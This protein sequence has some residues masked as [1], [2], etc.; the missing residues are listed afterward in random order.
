MDDTRLADGIPTLKTDWWNYGGLTRDVS[1]V[2]VPEHYID[3]FD[4]HLKRGTKNEIEGWVHVQGAPVGQRSKS[5]WK[6]AVNP[7][8]PRGKTDADGKAH[9]HVVNDKLQ[10]WS[11]EHPV[12]YHVTLSAGEDKL[13]DEIGFRTIEI[14]GTQIL[15]NGQPIFL[16]GINAHAEAP[17][18]TGRA[19]S[20]KDAET[21]LGWVHELGANFV[22]LAH[23]PHSERMDAPCRSHGHPGVV[24]NSC[25]LDCHFAD[26]AVLNKAESQLSEMIRRD[27][28]K[29]SVILWSVAN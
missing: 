24:R 2:E 4:L 25:L 9:I 10:L 27:R 23:Y 13:E 12:L 21:L 28:D 15:L 11:P 18:R 14:R 5:Q 22:R 17:Y 8:P 29:A 3:E 7:V 19:Y 1:L 26:T 20:E 16:K 6:K